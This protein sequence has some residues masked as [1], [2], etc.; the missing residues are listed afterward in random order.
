[1]SRAFPLCRQPRHEAR[2]RGALDACVRLLAE[3]LPAPALHAVV[4]TGS[5]ARGEG[6]VLPRGGVLHVLGDLEFFVIVDTA[7]RARQLTRPLADWSGEASARLARC[8]V[9]ATVEFG[10]LALPCLARR[11]RPSIF[12]HDL[13]EHGKTL[14]GA[15]AALELIPP[16]GPAAIPREE[17]LFLL[18]NR[19]IEQLDA[20]DRLDEP[21]GDVLLDVAYQRVKLTLDLAD[22]ALA[23]AGGHVAL[24]RRRP[25]AFAGLVAETPSLATLLPPGFSA[26]LTDAARA[27]LDP[28]SAGDWPLAGSRTVLRERLRRQIVAAAPATTALLAW[29]LTALLDGE[30]LAGSAIEALP[31]LLARYAR[32]PSLARRLRDWAKTLVNPRHAPFPITRARLARLALAST[33]R[34]LLYAA[35]GLAY[36][37]LAGH[38]DARFVE[39]VTGMLPVS[40]TAVPREPGAQRRAIVALWKWC[41]RNS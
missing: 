15:R 6:S 4:L 23:F 3:R 13:R 18:F 7:T 5:F 11:A 12:L 34:A 14:W 35:G 21:D 25:A 26:E 20:W 17:A 1:M 28:A 39:A 22:S 32:T 24:Y 40:G 38:G 37:G 8:G 16:F 19:M 10:P 30:R 29:E 41:V 33:P 31:A 9:H 27:K 2:M 36:L